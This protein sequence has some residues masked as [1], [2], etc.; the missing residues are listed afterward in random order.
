MEGNDANKLFVS[1]H[2]LF[3]KLK[4]NKKLVSSLKLCELS[5]TQKNNFIENFLLENPSTSCL[6]ELNKERA[7]VFHFSRVLPKKSFAV[8]A[9]RIL[10][11]CLLLSCMN[12]KVH[13]HC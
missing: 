2:A 12:F 4:N 6:H 10:K 1:S 13:V 11:V 8:N 9:K 3:T 5:P 7:R